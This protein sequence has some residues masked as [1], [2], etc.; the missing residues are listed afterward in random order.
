MPTGMIKVNVFYPAGEG[1]KFD[2]DYYVNTHVPIVSATLGEALKGSSFDAGRGGGAP[3][4]PAPFVA[5]ANMYFNSME[6]FGHAFAGASATLMADL[7]NFTDIEPVIQIS[8]VV[9]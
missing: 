9:A 2:M 4:L 3:G 1:K 7:P 8:E 6:E 5:I